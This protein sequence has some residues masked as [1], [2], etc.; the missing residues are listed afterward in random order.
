MGHGQSIATRSNWIGGVPIDAAQPTGSKYGEVGE[1][2]MNGFLLAIKQ[3][4]AVTGDRL[5]VVQGIERVMWER[6]QIDRS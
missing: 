4:T 1:I 6:N 2:T 5:V 3:V